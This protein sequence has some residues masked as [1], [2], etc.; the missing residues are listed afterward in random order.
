[1]GLMNKNRLFLKLGF[2]IGLVAAVAY[3]DEIRT[4]GSRVIENPSQDGNLILRVNDGGVKTD[5]LTVNGSTTDITGAADIVATSQFKAG[6]GTSSDPGIT[7]SADTDTGLFQTGANSG[8]LRIA[9]QGAE[10]VTIGNTG[11]VSISDTGSNGGNVPHNCSVTNA[12]TL[13]S[14]SPYVGSVTCAS[15][16]KEIAVGGGCDVTGVTGGTGT[17][18]Q[19]LMESAPTGSPTPTGWTCRHFTDGTDITI[20]AYAIC[21]D[22]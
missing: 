8:I 15:V 4:G 14:S 17:A 13:D 19:R 21:C 11:G 16:G 22:Y 7:F 2:L 1:M 6:G 9:T 20:R 3:A 18:G 5:A 10:R 12:T